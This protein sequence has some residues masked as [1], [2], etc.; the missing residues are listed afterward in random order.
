MIKL[1][2]DEKH[3]RRKKAMLLKVQKLFIIY[4]G[5][6][7]TLNTIKSG[8]FPLKTSQEKGRK[9]STPTQTFQ[10]LLIALAQVKTVGTFEKLPSEIRQLM[11]SLY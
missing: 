1:D 9:I 3:I 5:R 10:R 6:E 2:Q 4:E 7:L 8:I 11:L